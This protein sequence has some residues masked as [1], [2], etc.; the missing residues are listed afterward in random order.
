MANIPGTKFAQGAPS[1][2]TGQTTWQAPRQ[3]DGGI[4][5][6]VSKIGKELFNYGLNVERKK[7]VAEV[8]RNKRMI[9]EKGWLAN[10]SLVG[11]DEADGKVREQFHAEVNDIIG[12]S[13]YVD[14]NN[15]MGQY[16]NDVLPNWD[17]AIR[18][19]SLGIQSQNAELQSEYEADRNLSIGNLPGAVDIYD[20]SIKLN[21]GK[22]AYYE[23]KKKI[24]PAQSVLLMANRQVEAGNYDTTELDKLEDDK[25]TNRQVKLK[26]D[27]L[28]QIKSEHKIV[29]EAKEIEITSDILKATNANDP[30]RLSYEQ[31]R[32]KIIEAA[33]K[34]LF[35]DASQPREL[36]HFLD[37]QVKNVGKEPD[38]IERGQTR[39][40]I[41]DLID[42]GKK[43][44]A[45]KLWQL[46]AWMFTATDNDEI[47]DDIRGIGTKPTDVMLTDSLAAEGRFTSSYKT[48]LGISGASK[49]AL[50]N[51]ETN[52]MRRREQIRQWYK[53]NPNAT[54]GQNADAVEAILAP[55]KEDLAKEVVKRGWFK[56]LTGA[57]YGR[58]YPS[59]SEKIKSPY[60]E[61]PDAYQED[62]NW[63]IMKGKDRYRINP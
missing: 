38:Q 34:G 55:A 27:I 37:G 49:E 48:A 57:E 32:L 42:A 63:Y 20:K 59:Q 39:N 24:A 13:K 60:P 1:A 30:K 7:M 33:D 58:W 14:V 61:Y 21:P 29:S 31:I 47:N 23:E 3:G 2:N 43:D 51:I 18:V 45:K 54:P 28:A 62:G 19:K 46:N 16:A 22:R 44:E 50:A 12:S 6:A 53:N 15:T 41:Y 5:E 35:V 40:S 25:L 52:S 8:S 9:D 17:H 36:Q 26:Y 56:G 11:D 10:E 4:P